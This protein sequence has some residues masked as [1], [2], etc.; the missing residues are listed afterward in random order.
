MMKL[1][2]GNI[3]IAFLL[4][5][6]SN[7][8]LSAQSLSLDSCKMLA[9]RNNA[10]VKNA[11]LDVEA[12]QETKN[13]AF[14]KYFPNVSAMAGGYYA[15]NPLIEYGIEDVENA[16]ARQWL[17][18]LY[19]EY[20]AA[21][22]LSDK[23]SLCENGLLLSATAVQ[24]VYMGGQIVNGNR[25][26]KVG[27]EAS[28]LQSQLTQDKVL[29]QTEETYWLIVSLLEKRKTLQQAIVFLDTLHRDVIVAQQ[30]GLVTQNDTLKVVMKQHEMQSN[31]L[32][33]DNGIVLATMALCQSIGVDYTPEIE[34]TD[35][36]NRDKLLEDVARLQEPG[37][38]AARKEAHLLD[39]NV[40]AEQLKKKLAVGQTL[41]HVMVGVNASYGNP[42]FDKYSA[43]GLAFATLQVPITDWWETSH[44]IKQ[45]N[46]EIQKAEN[47]RE[48][49]MQKMLLEMRQAWQELQ[50]SQAQLNLQEITLR[51][52]ESN[53]NSARIHYQAG[54]IPVA[55]LLEA[56]TLY[57]QSQ[58][59]TVDAWIDL[60]VKCRHY[61]MLTG[62]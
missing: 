2:H 34:L 59:Q 40:Q 11:A 29:Q 7:G 39:L 27:V 42:I 46:K 23:I 41:P 1:K 25:L 32:K 60:Q 14:T 36:L 44:K 31:L 48:D 55:D 10:A 52:A 33:V 12:A 24:P 38:S 53:L 20:G 43:N 54:M 22:G 58:D 9:L 18:N 35:T 45:Y 30:A 26:A 47:E 21:L 13:Q 49:L 61:E 19:Y 17:H 6:L 51:D 56:Q 57:R 15:L 16:T 62:L 4:L 8:G 5:I 28:K 3:I 37:S 50:Q